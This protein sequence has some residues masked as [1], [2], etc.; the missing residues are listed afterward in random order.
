[1]PQTQ[2]IDF[3]Q[4]ARDHDARPFVSTDK[5]SIVLLPEGAGGFDVQYCPDAATLAR[6]LRRLPLLEAFYLNHA[7]PDAF[8]KKDLDENT[9]LGYPLS[10]VVDILRWHRIEND[11]SD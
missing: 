4:L 5:P 9:F 6:R 7:E 1:M 3:R 8:M 11:G 10:E 2:W